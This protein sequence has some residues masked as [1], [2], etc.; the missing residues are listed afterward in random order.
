MADPVEDRGSLIGRGAKGL[1]LRRRRWRAAGSTE[2]LFETASI[3]LA[4]FRA[5]QRVSTRLTSDLETSKNSTAVMASD[6]SE[7]RRTV[8]SASSCVVF[9]FPRQMRCPSKERTS[10]VIMGSRRCTEV[11]FH[12]AWTFQCPNLDFFVSYL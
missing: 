12:L 1:Y 6:Q 3:H 8:K 7:E 11:D 10:W 2:A 4:C 5:S 9:Q